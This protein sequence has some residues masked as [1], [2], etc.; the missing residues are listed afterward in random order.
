MTTHQDMRDV[1]T[2]CGRQ[3]ERPG[4]TGPDSMRSIMARHTPQEAA[5]LLNHLDSGSRAAWQ[6]QHEARSPQQADARFATAAELDALRVDAMWAT[7]E[8]GMRKP[9]E[10]LEDFAQRVRCQPGLE[11]EHEA[12]GCM[13]APDDILHNGSVTT[14]KP[15][16]RRCDS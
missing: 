12:G 1:A 15:S 7:V 9:A 2:S 8:T 10:P 13:S 5:E 6:A 3:G 14:P 4:F 11:T 16:P